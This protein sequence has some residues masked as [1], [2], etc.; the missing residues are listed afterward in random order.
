MISRRT[1]PLTGTSDRG[2]SSAPVAP[3]PRHVD[4]YTEDWEFVRCGFRW[5][6]I[7]ESG[8]ARFCGGCGDDITVRLA[9]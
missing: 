7:V 6:P 1:Q 9:A 8:G 4:F 5:H 3:L 2:S